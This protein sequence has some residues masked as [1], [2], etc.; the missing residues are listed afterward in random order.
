[1]LGEQSIHGPAT[2]SQTVHPATYPT[3]SPDEQQQAGKLFPVEILHR[4]ICLKG[5]RIGRPDSQTASGTGLYTLRSTTSILAVKC[6][7]GI[8]R[9]I[10]RCGVRDYTAMC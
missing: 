6:R 5:T 7:K 4:K 8:R 2:P 1:M 10:K 9:W 3:N